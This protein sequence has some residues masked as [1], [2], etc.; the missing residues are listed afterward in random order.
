M[1]KAPTEQDATRR[2]RGG[3]HGFLDRFRTTRTG[4]LGVRIAISFA[5]GLVVVAGLIMIPFPGPGWAVVIAGLA[6]LALEYAWAHHLMTFTARHVRA[7]LRWIGRQ[8]LLVRLAVAAACF[9][10]V[11]LILWV[12]LKLTFHFDYIEWGL[13][14]LGWRH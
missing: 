13:A 6:I 3:V 4:R 8:H 2:R 10:F 9:V 7:W 5:G 1:A 12:S 14:T 11:S